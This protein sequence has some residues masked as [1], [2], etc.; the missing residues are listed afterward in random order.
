M[1][2]YENVWDAIEPP[3]QAEHMKARANVMF[4]VTERIR[5]LGLSPADAAERLGVK[6]SRIY[7]LNAGKI[8]LFSLDKLIDFAAELGIH[9]EVTITAVA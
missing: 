6:R 3:D 5:A 9:V 8:N 2:M 7:E 4:A 1:D